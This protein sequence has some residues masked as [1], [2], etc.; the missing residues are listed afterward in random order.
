ME[1]IVLHNQSILDIAIQ[2]TGSVFNAFKIAVA[3]GL[4]VSDVL[5]PGNKLMIPED[6]ENNGDILNYYTAKKIQPATTF[7]EQGDAAQLGGIG[8]MRIGGNFKVS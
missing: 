1:I 6:V 4:A 2:H 5:G 8:Y 7:T 3:N